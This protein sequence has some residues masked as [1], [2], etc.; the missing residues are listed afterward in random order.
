[1]TTH[2]ADRLFALATSHGEPVASAAN[3]PILLDDPLT[4]WLVERGG[5]D[6]FLVEHRD[7][8]PASSFKHL[9]RA[10]E[11]MLV[12]GVGDSAGP[13]GAIAKGLQNS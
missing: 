9:I 10:T 11:G 6:V 5:L 2:Q 3:Q 4:A 7:G 13:L 12:F 8:Q 1:M